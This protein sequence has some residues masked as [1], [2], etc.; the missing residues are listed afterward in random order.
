MAT[1]RISDVIVPEVFNPYVQNLSKELSAILRS[2]A[3]VESQMLSQFL[4]GPG[5]TVHA[6]S[7]K[8]LVNEDEDIGS[9]DPA[10]LSTPSKIQTLQEIAV[11]L[12]RNKSWSS[13]DLTNALAGPDPMEAIARL[14]ATYWTRR[15]QKA[16]IATVG[17]IFLNND[18]ATDSYHTQYDMTHDIKG[19][20]YAAGTTDFSAEGFIDA[21]VTMG[22]AMGD[23][24]LVGMH[25]I[26]YARA[27]KNNLIDFIPDANGV[28]NIPTFLGRRVIVDD[29]ITQAAGV[30]ETWLFGSGAFAMGNGSARVPT[31]TDRIPGAGNGSGQDILHSRV[32]WALHPVGHAYIGTPA[33]GGPSNAATANNLGAAASWRRVFPERKQIPMARLITREF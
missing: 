27:Q 26:V 9:D 33:V 28:I 5:L 7:F 32:E 13:M 23:L 17:G 22:D 31:E 19:G 21:T 29:G 18:A 8:D 30:F 10:V 20:A 11:R 2:G 25:S 24:T 4:A 16:F 1:T 12:S 6:P 14:V 15:L 3:M